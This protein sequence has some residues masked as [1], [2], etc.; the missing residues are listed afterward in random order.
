[1][2]QDTRDSDFSAIIAS[3]VHDM[4]NALSMLLGALDEITEKCES[5]ACPSLKGF[6][7]VRYEGNRVNNSLIQLLSLYRIENSQYSLLLEENDLEECLEECF[8]ESE[9]L[10][11]LKGIT[12]ELNYDED[13]LWYFD[14]NL[15]IGMLNSVIN[16]SYKYT[17]SI[18][19]M[20]AYV[21]NNYLVI[22]VEDDGSGYPESMLH[23]GSGHEPG[24]DYKSGSTGLGLYFAKIIARLHTNK[25]KS[26][27]ITTTNDGIN[28][29]GKFSIYLP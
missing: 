21:E 12:T 28:G 9:G 24:I 1:M 5:S 8:L 14:R 2:T 20:N 22:S 25:D 7:H 26:G 10:L 19:K 18:I 6:S 23:G 3:S 16:N 17:K 27:Y 29:G 15:I 13:L 4:K 11:S